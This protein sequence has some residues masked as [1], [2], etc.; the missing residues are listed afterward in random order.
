M[1]WRMSVAIGL[2][3]AASRACNDACQIGSYWPGQIKGGFYRIVALDS[4]RRSASDGIAPNWD[5]KLAT[6]PKGGMTANAT[7]CP[8]LI[9]NF[10]QAIIFLG[11][12]FQGISCSVFV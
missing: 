6:S 3:V 5:Q 4:P 1:E 8:L 10:D 7:V 12:Q 2:S 11:L 9:E